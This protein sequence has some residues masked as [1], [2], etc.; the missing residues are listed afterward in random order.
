MADD[1]CSPWA[2]PHE[3]RSSMH[4]R[5]HG[6]RTELSLGHVPVDLGE[7]H[8]REILLPGGAVAEGDPGNRREDNEDRRVN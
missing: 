3:V 8:L 2:R 1:R 7:R 4:L 6:A 5:Q